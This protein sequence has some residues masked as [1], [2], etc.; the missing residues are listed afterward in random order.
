MVCSRVIARGLKHCPNEGK[1]W[2]Q[3]PVRSRNNG[4]RLRHDVDPPAPL[5]DLAKRAVVACGYDFGAVDMLY[6]PPSDQQQE[7]GWV[8]EINRMPGLDDYTATAYARAFIREA[9]RTR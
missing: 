3:L 9:S 6:I 8:L 5:R 4:W 7:Q 1:V 2:R